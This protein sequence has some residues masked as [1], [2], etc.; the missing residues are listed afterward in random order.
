MKLRFTE[1]VKAPAID[2]RQGPFRRIFLAAEQPFEIADPDNAAMLCR[3]GLFEVSTAKT[4]TG[5]SEQIATHKAP[6][7]EQ[8]TAPKP[9]EQ[10]PTTVDSKEEK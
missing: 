2:L 7:P 1:S 10:L 3:T 5:G 8:T 4:D 9:A 6:Q